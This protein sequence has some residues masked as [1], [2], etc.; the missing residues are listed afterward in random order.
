MLLLNPASG[1]PIYRQIMDQIRRL[2]QSDQLKTGDELPS[3]RD[4]A[5]QYRLN[6]MTV[7]KAYSLLETEGWIERQRGKPMRVKAQTMASAADRAELL[8]PQLAALILSAQQ[9]ELPLQTVVQ[10]LAQHWP[11]PID[12]TQTVDLPNK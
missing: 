10:L 11:T 7:S 4:I 12:N 9:L 6:P 8:Q 1:E 5:L 3:V 2:I